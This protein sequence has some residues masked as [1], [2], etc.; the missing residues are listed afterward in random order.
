MEQQQDKIPLFKTWK[1]WYI[2]VLLVLV[3]LIIG[4]YFF[5]KQFA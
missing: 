5:T 2:F 3:L 1:A 4:F